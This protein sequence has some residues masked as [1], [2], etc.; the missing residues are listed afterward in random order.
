MAPARPNV[1]LEQP[2]TMTEQT[3]TPVWPSLEHIAQMATHASVVMQLDS[4]HLMPS[5][6]VHVLQGRGRHCHGLHANSV[7]QTKPGLWVSAT[8]ALPDGRRHQIAA[9]VSSVTQMQQ[10]ATAHV[11]SVPLAKSQTWS[12]RHV[13]RV[14]M[15]RP[16]SVANAMIV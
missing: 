9:R 12:V 6:A 15:A 16:A 8:P 2:Q 13:I 10:A 4:T 14:P 11:P 7:V 1:R 5:P 3:V